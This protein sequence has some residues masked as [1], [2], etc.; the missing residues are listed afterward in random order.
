[1]RH[2]PPVSEQSSQISELAEL[3]NEFQ[4]NE[5]RLRLGELMVTFKRRPKRS[6]TSERGADGG[7]DEPILESTKEE[8][9]HGSPV[10][11]PMTGIYYASPSP[12]SPPFVKVGD[13]VTAGQTIG[14]IEAMKVFNEIPSPVG[15]IVQKI[16]SANGDL[17]QNG[18]ILLYI[19]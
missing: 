5:A 17:V 1:M 7:S 6:L 13:E 3:M 2:N 18:D 10:A 14:L 9:S 11:S 8:V 16:N 12:S 4:L 19:A 15:G